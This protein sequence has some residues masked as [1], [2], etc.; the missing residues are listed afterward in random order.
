MSGGVIAE[1]LADAALSDGV[2]AVDALGV[3]LQQDIDAMPSSRGGLGW[4]GA[5]VQ[6]QRQAGVPYVV[7]LLASGDFCSAS[8]S[9]D[10]RAAA[11]ERRMVMSTSS[12]PHIPVNSLPPGPVPNSVMCAWR[13]LADSEC[14]GTMRVSSWARSVAA[15]PH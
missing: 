14:T 1:C 7:T 5:G 2:L 10:S 13:T 6:P 9:A 8:V 3:D 15:D 12:R 4:R 11:H